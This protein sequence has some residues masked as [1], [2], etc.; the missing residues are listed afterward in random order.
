MT[1]EAQWTKP[2]TLGSDDV[3]LGLADETKPSPR[4]EVKHTP[5]P[6]HSE[7]EAVLR[8]QNMF[9]G[10]KARKRVRGIAKTVYE[11]LYDE[12]SARDYYWNKTTGEAQ[13]S[14]PKTLYWEDA[15]MA[16]PDTAKPS[17]RVHSKPK[18][19]VSHTPRIVQ[20]PEDAAEFIQCMVSR[21]G[22]RRAVV[23]GRS[24]CR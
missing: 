6:I 18:R 17:P 3:P 4:P 7:E 13:W 9:R 10:W 15:P 8:I 1:D 20:D 22:L 11:K 23:W 24:K 12:E 16:P 19:L 21:A 5:R 2:R 14:K